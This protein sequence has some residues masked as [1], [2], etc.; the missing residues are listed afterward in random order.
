LVSEASVLTLKIPSHS[1]NI[2]PR[3]RA[4]IAAGQSPYRGFP[5]ASPLPM[6]LADFAACFSSGVSID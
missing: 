6:Y 1:V 4:T 5:H 3:T 2:T